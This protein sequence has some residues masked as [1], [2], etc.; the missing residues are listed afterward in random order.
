MHAVLR[1]HFPEQSVWSL[2]AIVVWAR[3]HGY[4]PQPA[5]EVCAPEPRCSSSSSYSEPVRIMDW[6]E[7]AQKSDAVSESEDE[8]DVEAVQPAHVKGE[9]CR[10]GADASAGCRQVLSSGCCVTVRL[11][12]KAP[13]CADVEVL[14]LGVELW[15][16]CYSEVAAGSPPVC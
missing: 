14:N 8:I 13:L 7:T 11:Q 6:L 16:L 3:M 5:Q 1:S 2:R 15:L 12:Q 10:A 4:C 9:W